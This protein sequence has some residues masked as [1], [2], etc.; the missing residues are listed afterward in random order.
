MMLP[1]LSNIRYKGGVTSYLE[2]L[3]HKPTTSAAQLNL[4]QATSHELLALV[5]V[6]QVSVAAGRNEVQQRQQ[7]RSTPKLKINSPK[8]S[9][10]LAL[11]LQP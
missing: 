10:W 4:A 3:N 5:N 2:V 11:Q 6:Y 7:R 9:S 1:R 8:K